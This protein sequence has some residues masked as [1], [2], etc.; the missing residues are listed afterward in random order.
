MSSRIFILVAASAFLVGGA[1]VAE[2]KGSSARGGGS[3]V[4]PG[5]TIYGEKESPVGLFITPWRN[6]YADSRLT[7]P[8]QPLNDAA[9]PLDAETL[10][11]QVTY[12]RV[13][14]ERRRTERSAD[15]AVTH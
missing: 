5:I 9:Q 1:A 6:A 4:E 8:K 13:I 2:D 11:K 3:Q 12:D 7:Q 14:D 15:A 10:H